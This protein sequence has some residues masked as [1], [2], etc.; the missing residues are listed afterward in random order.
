MIRKHSCS[1]Y[2]F[3]HGERVG[4]RACEAEAMYSDAKGHLTNT[5]LLVLKDGSVSSNVRV[6]RRPEQVAE[7]ARNGVGVLTTHV[8]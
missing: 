8:R 4:Q 3:S 6:H 7:C 5:A 1:S 2:Y